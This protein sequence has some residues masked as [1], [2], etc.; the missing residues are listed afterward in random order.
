MCAEN[1]WGRLEVRHGDSDVDD[2]P[3]LD[4]GS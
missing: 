3:A 2:V 4:P 1:I